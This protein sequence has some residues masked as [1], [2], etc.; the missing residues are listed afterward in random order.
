MQIPL[1]QSL[2]RVERALPRWCRERAD[3]GILITDIHLRIV[4]W[5]RWLEMRTKRTEAEVSG[6]LLF[7]IFPELTKRGFDQYYSAAI[8]GQAQ[9]ISQQLHNYLFAVPVKELSFQEMPQSARIW[10]LVV[11]DQVVGTVTLIEDVTE[12]IVSEREL[13]KQIDVQRSA[14]AMA[15]GA[16]KA[17]DEFLATLSHEIRTPLNAVMGWTRILREREVDSDMLSRALEVIDRNATA[18]AKMIDDLLDMARIV[19]GKVRLDMQPVDLLAVTLAAIDVTAPSATAKRIIIRQRLDPKVAGVF[20]DPQ[21]LQQVIWN[22]LSNS[23]KFTE[24]DGFIDIRLEQVEQRVRVTITDSGRGI[25]KEFLPFVF[26]R[27]RQGDSS[28]TRREGGLGLGLALVRELIE[29]HGGSVRAESPGENKGSTFVIELPTTVAPEVHQ[30]VV[31]ADG[32]SGDIS[33]LDGVHVLVVEDETD[34]REMVVTALT[35]WGARVTPAASCKEALAAI[36]DASPGNRPD[37]ILSDIGMPREDG[38]D[39]IRQLRALTPERGGRIPAIAVTGYANINDR[40]RVLAA[41]YQAYV[42][43]PANLSNLAEAVARIARPLK[44]GPILARRHGPDQS[45]R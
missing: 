38:Y 26:E 41:G 43:K 34:A 8:A 21:R 3:H 16:L 28:S 4:M 39:L 37:V 5:N 14:R 33:S 44:A 25:R 20:G 27:F 7:E 15:E 31:D 32:L 29:L 11:D 1:S 24:P 18:Q 40:D 35:G 45:L 13:R 6:R 36:V 12:R 42:A 22:L 23:I 2:E 17:K 30:H 9:V 19:T 10:P